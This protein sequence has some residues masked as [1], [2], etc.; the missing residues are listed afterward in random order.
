[1]PKLFSRKIFDII[2]PEKIEEKISPEI[3]IKEG[4]PFQPRPKKPLKIFFLLIIFLLILG[5]VFSYFAFQKAEIIIWPKT[6]EF[7]LEE[8]VIIDVEAKEVEFSTNT[9][10]G[11]I[12]KEK[13]RTTQEFPSSGKGLREAK[14]EGIIRVYNNYHLSQPLVANTR[15][16]PPLERILYFRTTRR[17]TVPAKSYVDIEVVADKP[18]EEYNIGPSTFSV[19]GLAGLSQY[20]SVYGKSFE[21]MKGGFKGEA[22]EVTQQDLEKAENILEEK[23]LTSIKMS[24]EDKVAEDVI[25]LEEASKKDFSAPTFSAK[26]GDEKTSFVAEEELSFIALTFK[27]SDLENLAKEYILSQ[28]SKDQKMDLKSLKISYSSETV[29]IDKGKMTLNLNF[30]AKVYFEILEDYIK[31]GLAG[32]LLPEARD[33]LTNDPR[34]TKLE[35]NLWPFWAKRIPQDT[36]KIKIEQR[37]D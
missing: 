33:S 7:S 16:Q 6:Q 9:I 24:L 20:Y 19:P 14:A 10:P 17:I 1:M 26:A 12:I 11:D 35:I 34:I 30:S 13:Q 18:G 29:S 37:I 8:K 23:L 27:K 2:P 21:P 32:K 4:I 36:E 15:F 22:P 5:G 3:R 31:E 28:I 25:I